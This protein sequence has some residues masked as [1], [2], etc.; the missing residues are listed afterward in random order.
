MGKVGIVIVVFLVLAVALV[1]G[2]M[3]GCYTSGGRL[4]NIG[5]VFE[6][7]FGGNRVVR[8]LMLGEDNTGLSGDRRGLSDTIMLI[9]IDLDA[10]HL[11]ALSI[12]RD[13]RIDLSTYGYGMC[14]INAAHV[15]G[16]PA[17]TEMV[18]E[19]LI[20]IRPDYYIKTNIE[21]FKSLV[22]TL[23]G[24]EIY[25]EKDMH[26]RDRHGGLYINLKKGRQ[27]LDG[28]KAMQYVRFRHDV[29]GDITRIERQQK[30]MKA[31]SEKALAAQNIPKLPYTIRAVMKNV[32]TDM[33]PKD[34]VCLAT[35][36]SQLDMSRVK[37]GMLPGAPQNIDGVSYWIADP[38]ERITEVVQELFFPP[39]PGL[40]TI[41][42]LNGSGID[43][44]AQQVAA[45]LRQQGYD[46]VSV[47]N[48]GSYDHTSTDVVSHNETQGAD[49]VAAILGSSIVEYKKDPSAK[50]DITV[51]VGKNCALISPIN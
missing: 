50:A 29:M 2:A 34:A 19:Q 4:G 41:E 7:P 16:G 24:V 26:Y 43:G 27:L 23:G 44:A 35:F 30:F 8:I 36:V 33:T 21:G 48:A 28:E 51:I 47:G 32:K 46:V 38:P 3:L 20:G 40:P 14:K 45:A 25:V 9:S 39:T 22:D 18:V 13:T 17:M 11:A 49:Q 15:Y 31:L 1:I 6:P 12:P 5:Q 42:V 10:K 37:T